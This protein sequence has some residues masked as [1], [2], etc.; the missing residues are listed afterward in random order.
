MKKRLHSLMILLFLGNVAV[1]SH[2]VGGEFELLHI[3]G[4]QYR[5]NMILYFDD[6]HGE[7]GARE[8]WV[9]VG[10]FEKRSN[11]LVSLVQL[12]LESE[13]NVNYTQPICSHGELVTERFLYTTNLTLPPEIYNDP[14]GYYIAWERCCRNYNISNIYSEDQ[15]SNPR[16]TARYAGQTFYLEFPPVV[17]DGIPFVDS[18]PR[19]FPPLNDYACTSRPYYADFTGRDDDN[20]SLVYSLVT[21]LSTHTGEP[22]PTDY[23]PAP[24]PYPPVQWRPANPFIGSNRDF[25]LSNIMDGNPDLSISS[26]GILR[27]T[28]QI[29]GLF[30]FAVK[31]E[32]YRDK[33]KIGETRRDF[34]M[35]VVRGCAPANPP[36]IVGRRF[37][38]ANFSNDNPLSIFFPNTTLDDQRCIVVRVSDLDSKNPEDNF[39]ENVTIKAVALNFNNQTIQNIIPQLNG[40]TL[41]NGS[42]AD[43]KICFPE[44]PYIN[45]VAKIGIIALDDACSVP[46]TDT[47]KINLIVEPPTNNKP[48]FVIPPTPSEDPITVTLKEGTSMSWSI[49]VK[50]DDLNSITVTEKPEGFVTS[51][52]GIKFVTQQNNGTVNATVTWDAFC[53]IY[54]FTK[55]SEFAYSVIFEDQD[56]CNTIDPISKTFN[57][58]VELQNNASPTIMTDLTATPQRYING[59][60]KKIYET[61][62][63]KVTGSD[64]IDND[65]LT[66]TGKL[67]GGNYSDYGVE[68][69][70]PVASNRGT[71]TQDFLWTLKCA[72]FDLSKKIDFDFQFVVL[73]EK[74]KCRLYLSDTV[75][76]SVTVL[77]P[78]NTAPSIQ[79]TIIN[80]TPETSGNEIN[81]FVRT[82][83]DILI[84]GTDS[85]VFGQKDILTIDMEVVG[86]QRPEG[87][88]FEPATGTSPL[89]ATFNWISNCS[90]IT[91]DNYKDKFQFRF[92]VTDNRCFSSKKDSVDVYIQIEDNKSDFESFK[93]PN[94]FSPNQDNYNQYF[95][96]EVEDLQTRQITNILPKDNCF[97]QYDGIR[98]Y[99]RWGK[100]LFQ[101]KG[102]DFKWDGNNQPAGTYF[103]FINFTNKEFRGTVTIVY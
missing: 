13:T 29:P 4:Y 72:P 93:P 15:N 18:T 11:R 30:V 16:G 63:F 36:N 41:V 87:I 79:V 19:L 95:T 59:I 96:M 42:T 58:K 78:D 94:F 80:P 9:Q 44:C 97:V 70:P 45:G 65:L 77:P 81:T 76:V 101:S 98:I 46:L 10:I 66:L 51:Q 69:T 85:D 92:K 62:Q 31:V 88:T 84:R 68:I 67:L 39:T 14:Q 48:Y 91:V 52:V 8:G 82:P 60:T 75:D 21:P 53:D 74:N 89:E 28:P 27:V 100:E 20:D 83:I 103:Y 73:D 38:D 90:L 7:P 26:N 2:I 35:L 12:P 37:Q 86:K 34:Q 3:Q 6:I 49:V 40:A 5:L 25:S 56:K 61:L 23:I 54:N 71:A 32:E 47:L 64:L 50:D 17:K 33:I 102:R 55:K 43:F 99:N 1:A 22:Y 24:Y 57:L